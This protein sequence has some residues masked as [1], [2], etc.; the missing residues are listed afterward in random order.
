MRILFAA[1]ELHFPDNMGGSRMDVHDLA[2]T[3]RE[4]GHDVAVLGI[5][6]GRNRLLGYRMLEAVTG[7]CLLRR[8]D[9]G[10]GYETARCG[11]WQVPRLL[12]ADLTRRPPDLVITQGPG[13]ERLAGIAATQ[14]VRAVMRITSAAEA[15]LLAGA[16]RDDPDVNAAI[17]SPLVTLVTVSRFLATLTAGLLGVAPAVIYPPVRLEACLAGD[18]KPDHITF[19]NPIPMK[20][21]DVALQVAAL[22][23]HRRFVFAEAWNMRGEEREALERGISGLANVSLRPRSV[24]LADVYRSTALL[25]VPSQCPEAFSRVVLEACANGIPVLASRTGG[26]P[27][28]MGESGVLLGA[29]DPADRWAGAIEAILADPGRL[30][31]AALANAQRAELSMPFVAAQYL[32]LASGP[33]GT[34]VNGEPSAT[35]REFG[36]ITPPA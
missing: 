36:A 16:A 34:A 23:P 1:N 26:V 8:V 21:R 11:S 27:E 33:A 13:G 19:V 28:A 30:G 5:L 6:R 2:L 31:T 12:R 25:L 15:E 17:H 10:N 22:L 9:P 7:K 29:A 3:F 20:G 32:V 18:R 24:G 4:Q 35:V 14:E